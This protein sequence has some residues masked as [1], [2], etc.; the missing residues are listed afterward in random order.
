MS[1]KRISFGKRGEDIAVQH[2][3]SKGF[4]IEARNYR[5]K[6]GEIDI[7]CKDDDTYVF[8]EVKTRKN[9]GFGHPTEAVDSRKQGQI[10]RTALFYLSSNNLLDKPVRFDVIGVICDQEIPDI[11]HITGAF[12]VP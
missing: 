6:T 1:K 5:Q 8:V 3:R 12:E 7:I 10:C 11:T 4:R 9:T 2:L